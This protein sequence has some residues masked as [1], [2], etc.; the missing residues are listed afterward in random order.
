MAIEQHEIEKF[1]RSILTQNLPEFQV[2]EKALD[3]LLKARGGTIPLAGGGMT[4]EFSVNQF[5]EIKNVLVTDGFIQAIKL[6]RSITNLG[7]K[8]GKGMVEDMENRFGCK[9]K[10]YPPNK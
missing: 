7:L 1:L 4:F 2:R 9:R 8:E 10:E 3:L 5:D 6:V